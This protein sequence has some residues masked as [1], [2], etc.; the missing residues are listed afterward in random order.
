M[1]KDEQQTAAPY[2]HTTQRNLSMSNQATSPYL[3][4][5]Y[6]NREVYLHSLARE[7]NVALTS[8][9]ALAQLLGPSEDF[10][11]LPAELEDFS[12]FL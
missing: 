6:P 5:G 1:T 10:D 9:L 3:S 4:H 7:Y 11:G 12:T 2:S 8:V